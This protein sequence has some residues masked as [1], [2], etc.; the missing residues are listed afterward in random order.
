VCILGDLLEALEYLSLC[1]PYYF[2]THWK[3][4]W[5]HPPVFPLR[6]SEKLWL[7]LFM[8]IFVLLPPNVDLRV[9]CYLTL[10]PAAV[11]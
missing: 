6:F 9:A 1:Y 5:F 3:G 11:A 2:A 8:I 10:I 4:L 7:V